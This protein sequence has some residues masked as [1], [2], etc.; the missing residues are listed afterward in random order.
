MPSPSDPPVP[1]PH[2]DTIVAP[3]TAPLPAG[4][5]VL[6]LSG[7]LA[8][9]IARQLSDLSQLPPG[10]LQYATLRAGGV[11][12]DHGYV[13]GFAAPR[14]FT[15]E[16]VAELQVHGS[17][18]VIDALLA[19]CVAAGARL[20]RPGE[21]SQ[22]AFEHGKLDLLQA[23]ALADL[24]SARAESARKAALLT[25]DG[26]LSAA[27]AD[28]R[29]P[30]LAALAEV[31][32]RIDFVAEPHLAEVDRPALLAQLDQLDGALTALAQTATAG[33][34]RLHGARVVLYG[35]PNAGKSTLLNAL[36]G[37]DRALVDAR[38]GTTRD[39][40]EVQTAPDGVLVT[41]VDTAGVRE[42]AD[43]VEQA[44][45][46]RA[47][48]AASHA[49]VVLWLED[50]AAPRL[51]VA[52][53]P[54]TATVLRVLSKADLP[55][56]PDWQDAGDIAR[57]IA[58]CAAR[59]ADIARLRAAVVAA[60]R[61]ATAV[62][63]VVLSRARHV[64]AVQTALQAVARARIALDSALPLELLAADLR[65]AA[66]ALDELTGAIA[67]DDVYAAVFAQFCVGK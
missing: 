31:E 64:A 5:A 36:C 52:P 1:P 9:P 20:A 48:Q 44:G 61:A 16:D 6:R 57:A 29:T 45:V 37:A 59:P 63:D 7:P 34:I 42:S 51:P 25:L 28:L 22:R 49:D 4:L 19:A 17:L 32:A 30:L 66:T 23:E 26:A 50:R 65:D 67:A 18:A 53:P 35:A 21:F 27:L 38:P 8:W 60:I 39:T 15:G 33:R 2:P 24:I 14:S 10:L 62:G 43:S 54:G 11:V 40:I 46:L 3:A 58:V 13:V 12:L 56:H 55:P 41:W 47:E